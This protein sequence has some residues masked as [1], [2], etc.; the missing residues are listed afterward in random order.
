M[1]IGIEISDSRE[2]LVKDLKS[3]KESKIER[4]GRERE[5]EIESVCWV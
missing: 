4:G 2:I 1:I 3:H 5:R